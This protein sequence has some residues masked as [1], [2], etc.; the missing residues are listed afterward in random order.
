MR[1]AR[2]ALFV[3][4]PT[5]FVPPGRVPRRLIRSTCCTTCGRRGATMALVGAGAFARAISRGFVRLVLPPPEKLRT[6]PGKPPIVPPSMG[7]GTG[8][9]AAGVG[10]MGAGAGA[11]GAAGGGATGTTRMGSTGMGAGAA[12]TGISCPKTIPAPARSRATIGSHWNSVEIFCSLVAVLVWH[13]PELDPAFTRGI[14][15]FINGCRRVRFVTG[16]RST[17]RAKRNQ[18]LRAYFSWFMERF[19]IKKGISSRNA[20]FFIRLEGVMSRNK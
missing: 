14:F 4:P 7:P 11:I 20:E 17:H 15:I 10:S 3:P 6:P 19:R 18:G 9:G 1:S 2:T 13:S 12:G 5:L 8:A 16:K